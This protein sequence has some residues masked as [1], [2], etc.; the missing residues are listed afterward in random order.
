MGAYV[1]WKENHPRST[2]TSCQ[3]EINGS[4]Q[5]LRDDERRTGCSEGNQ[6]NRVGHAGSVLVARH[7]GEA[8]RIVPSTDVELATAF[9]AIIANKRHPSAELNRLGEELA[10][11]PSESDASVANNTTEKGQVKPFTTQVTP[12]LSIGDSSVTASGKEVDNMRTQIA[13]LTRDNAM[14]NG[15]VATSEALVTRLQQRSDGWN[16][17]IKELQINVKDVQQLVTSFAARIEDENGRATCPNWFMNRWLIAF[18]S[19]LLERYA[20]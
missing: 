1:T 11:Y 9:Q 14:L 16:A 19:Y 4:L 6:D 8:V 3:T 17:R 13:T 18:A 2:L 15:Q 7:F 10:Q 5:R 12:L 20:W